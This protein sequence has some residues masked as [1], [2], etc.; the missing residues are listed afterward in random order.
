MNQKKNSIQQKQIQL[1][2]KIQLSTKMSVFKSLFKRV[3]RR[4]NKTSLH[5]MQKILH[6][7][8]YFFQFVFLR[9]EF[10][11]HIPDIVSM[12]SHLKNTR[13][14]CDEILVNKGV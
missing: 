1:S 10:F 3:K 5:Q 13:W 11:K 6:I 4:T 7:H 8:F 9:L 2:N 12:L 14:K